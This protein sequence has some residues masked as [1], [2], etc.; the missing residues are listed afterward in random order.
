[1]YLNVEVVKDFP[2]HGFVAR[3]VMSRT[4]DLLTRFSVGLGVR[5]VTGH[6]DFRLQVPRAH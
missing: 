4:D 2:V 1:M 5:Q 6:Q 3:V